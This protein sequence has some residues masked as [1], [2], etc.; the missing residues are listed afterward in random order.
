MHNSVAGQVLMLAWSSIRCKLQE[1][2]L[3]NPPSFERLR[4]TPRLQP[5]GYKSLM[6]ILRNLLGGVG[7]RNLKQVPIRCEPHQSALSNPPLFG[8]R[9]ATPRLQPN[10]D[11]SLTGNLHTLFLGASGTGQGWRNPARI[12]TI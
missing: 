12:K 11:K 4:P 2:A 5:N 7:G 10:G 3:G 9:R 8:L 1:S 6:G